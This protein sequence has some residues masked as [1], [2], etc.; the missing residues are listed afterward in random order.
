MTSQINTTAVVINVLSKEYICNDQLTNIRAA[1]LNVYG[2][3]QILELI[4]VL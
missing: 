2:M 3:S 1:R 4:V